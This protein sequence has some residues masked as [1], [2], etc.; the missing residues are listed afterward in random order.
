LQALFGKKCLKR[1]RQ[2]F[3]LNDKNED[4]RLEFDEILQAF[5][6]LGYRA[7]RAD[8][9]QWLQQ[10]IRKHSGGVD[11]AEFVAAYASIFGSSDVAMKGEADVSVSS[12]KSSS[13]KS[14]QAFRSKRGRTATANEG[15]AEQQYWEGL[16]GPKRVHQLRYA[17]DI[18][19]SNNLVTVRRLRDALWELNH[20]VSPFHLKQW[21]REMD[22]SMTDQLSFWEFCFTYHHLFVLQDEQD[23]DGAVSG[24]H[25]SFCSRPFYLIILHR[26]E[27]DFMPLQPIKCLKKS[28]RA[29]GV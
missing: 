12:K 29:G 5:C 25:P 8:V 16:M 6:E 1:F 24:V 13:T 18:H 9:R 27:S 26:W 15:L 17:F 23:T 11:F 10:Q 2:I 14:L 22:L 7:S 20:D 21:L 3:D 28:M 4:G 19:Q